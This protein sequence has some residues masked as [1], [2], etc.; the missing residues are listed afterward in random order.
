M[1][2][3]TQAEYRKK[4]RRISKQHDLL[5]PRCD[6]NLHGLFEESDALRPCPEC[7]R[8]VSPGAAV[9][10]WCALRNSRPFTLVT[11][12]S[13]PAHLLV[14]IAIVMIN[15]IFDI[16]D[17][18]AVSI[19]FC[20]VVLQLIAVL[21]CAWRMQ[22]AK[23]PARN[24]YFAAAIAVLCAIGNVGTFVLTVLVSGFFLSMIV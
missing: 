11:A 8:L 14:I 19:W 16:G 22:L 13:G 18:T 12:L 2:A 3:N 9:L 20:S 5:C 10:G 6:Y 23:H 24:P 21:Y 4:A 7:G 1:P 15:G 17:W